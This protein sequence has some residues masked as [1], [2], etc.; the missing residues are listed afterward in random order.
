MAAAEIRID[1]V[2]LSKQTCTTSE[3]IKIQVKAVFTGTIP[4]DVPASLPLGL[5]FTLGGDDI[6]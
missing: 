5:G 2:T 6:E 4:P 3:K 1:A